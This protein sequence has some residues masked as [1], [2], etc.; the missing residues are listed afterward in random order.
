MTPRRRWLVGAVVGAAVVAAGAG[1]AVGTQIKSPAQ[2]AAETAPP[3]ASL[4]AVPVERKTLTTEVVVRGVVRHGTPQPLAIA[5][6]P[7]KPESP[8][9][10]SLPT[11][12]ATIDE[13]TLA[14][15]IAGRPVLAF[16]GAQPSYRDLS[17]GTSGSDVMQSRRSARTSA[18]LARHDRRSLRQRDGGRDGRPLS[19]RGLGSL[20]SHAHTTT[21]PTHRARG[22]CGGRG[23]TIASEV[24]ARDRG[25]AH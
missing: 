25:D 4:I 3:D 9:V 11:L 15:A 12:G 17:V 6:S 10:T 18:A 2:V 5:T 14:L 13:G 22:G 7:L 20:R 21:G 19:T 1:W 24:G 8:V 23:S 16:R